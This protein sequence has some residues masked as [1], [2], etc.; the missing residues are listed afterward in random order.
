MS[1]NRKLSQRYLSQQL[2]VG[3]GISLILAGLGVVGINY[4]LDQQ[5]LEEHEQEYAESLT[6]SL[7][8]ATEGLIE[9]QN[10]SILRR[11]VQNY[12]TL[13]GVL[14]ISIV[15]PGR[16]V[17]AHSSSIEQN[18]PYTSIHP[19]L[20][21]A[22]EQAAT[23]GVPVTAQLK[24][25]QQP[26]LAQILPFSSTLF[27]I[28]RQRG[29]AIAIIDLEHI[30]Q[31]AR[32]TLLT[33]TVALFVGVLAVL[34]LMGLFVKRLILTPLYQLNQAIESSKESGIFFLPKTLPNH[35]IKSLAETFETVFAE[36]QQAE[37]ELLA[38][39]GAMEDV[40]LV[41]DAN[42]FYRKIPVTNSPNL[43]KLTPD[44]VGKNINDVLSAKSANFFQGYVQQVLQNKQTVQ[45]EYSLPIQEQTIWFDATVAPFEE[46]SVI[47]VARDITER[48]VA[49]QILQ[50]KEAFLRSLY[51]G[52]EHLIFVVNVLENGE[53]RYEG[54]NE[55]TAKA[56]G[57]STVEIRE[58]TLQEIF[59][60][61]QGT[62]IHQRYTKCVKAERTIT[63]EECL[64]FHEQETWWLTTLNP[65]WNSEGRIYRIVG[66]TFEITH[67]K[68]AEAQLQQQAQE[69]QQTLEELKRTQAQLI[70][71]EKMS[72]LGQTVAGVAHEINNPISFIHGNLPHLKGYTQ[73]LLELL[74]LYQEHYP[75]PSSEIQA[76]KE[77]IELDFITQDID[78]ILKS[79][80]T[81]TERI[82]DIVT[83]LR[84]FSHL[85][86]ADLKTV[87]LHQ[88]IDST[89]MILQN[90]FKGTT[91]FPDIEII[92]EYS[93]LPKVECYPGQLNQVFLNI[94]NNA[95]DALH[96]F[97]QNRTS[98]VPQKYLST[99]WIRTE[100]L[101]NNWVKI[102]IADN[103]S[104][105]KEEVR[106]C[107]FD[108]F[109]T[110][111]PVGKGT[112][113]GLS[114]SYQIITEKHHGELSC[115]SRWGEGTE[116]V[117][118]IPVKQSGQSS[119]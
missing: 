118:S 71:S 16:M 92:K 61:E 29:V 8:F 6:Q 103:A 117:I 1:K 58:K 2:L 60:Q 67:R 21:S 81:G 59:G 41:L 17:L 15:S 57:K 112:G 39:F 99:I 18:A 23:T 42:G 34:V 25:A 107:V 28:S 4:R 69:L 77:E 47:W 93:N 106:S 114:V 55:P 115:S 65:L 88:N 31:D 73:D 66:T 24:I 74:Q 100:A 26:A 30:R 119:V 108:P 116:F 110:T 62:A 70:Q 12:A 32:K 79:M 113:L 63:Y 83:S 96:E 52:V 36:R 14:E 86:E 95:I 68:K 84:T 35:E 111:K 45:L 102:A 27:G 97:H 38:L 104:G 20:T 46:D 51:D 3:C 5:Y 90:R 91:K 10:L 80:Q 76:R 101:E 48:K 54:W 40:I 19:E 37:T 44:L 56:T 87:D 50:E 33:S 49:E 72:S 109:F 94:L 22:I 7:E 53:F 64:V 13:P 85:D 105:M 43:Y 75:T 11:V 89:L 9:I 78:N 98:E 82:R